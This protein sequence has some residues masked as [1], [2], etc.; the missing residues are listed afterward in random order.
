MR[1]SPE[2]L[3][4]AIVRAQAGD[5]TA[6]EQIL[7]DF[8]VDIKRFARSGFFIMGAEREDVEQEAR[9]GLWKAI[10]QFR[11]DRGQID[12]RTF[13]IRVCV[14]RSVITALN[15]ARKRRMEPLNFGCSLDVKIAT[16]EDG[17]GQPLSEFIADPDADLES[18][19]LTAEQAH[20]LDELI[21]VELTDLERDSYESYVAGNTYREIAKAIHET[22]KTVDNALMRVRSKA[23]PVMEK[24]EDQI[25][26]DKLYEEEFDEDLSEWNPDEG[27]EDFFENQN[28]QKVLDEE[29]AETDEVD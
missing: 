14:K 4:D 10:M 8:E 12:F 2:E 13:A 25:A 9:I 3:S 21:R 20:E 11:P 22:E 29:V 18:I 1:L 17:D 7:K 19:I 24:Y 15:I 5:N 6:V 26:R 16:S 23:K 28:W 27:A